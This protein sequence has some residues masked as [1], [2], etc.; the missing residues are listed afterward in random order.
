MS[1]VG[2]RSMILKKLQEIAPDLE[3]DSDETRSVVERLK[4]LEHD[5][6]QFEAA[7]CS[8][9]LM[10]RRL[11]GQ[12]RRFFELENFTVIGE[13][14]TP[15][16]GR[17]STA[18]IKV[19]VGGEHEMTAAEGDGP[20]HALDRALRKALGVF[21]PEL[22][23]MKLT[24]FKVRVLNPQEAT[25]AKVR[26]LIESTDGRDIWTTVGVS[27]DII[28]ASCLALVD[29]IEYKLMRKAGERSRAAL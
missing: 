14:P 29:S 1:E 28:E 13:M 15:S 12:S 19:K 8:F 9:E 11:L 7:E 21:Y 17:T 5:G 2:G 26:V 18:L 24:D 27:T 23:E 3:K 22:S 10:V 16:D 25:A 4:S 6:Y 20:V